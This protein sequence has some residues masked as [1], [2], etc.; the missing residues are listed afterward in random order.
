MSK[1]LHFAVLVTVAALLA[2]SNSETTPVPTNSAAPA[3]MPVPSPKSEPTATAMSTPT[4]ETMATPDPTPTKAPTATPEPAPTPGPEVMPEPAGATG[5]IAPLRMDDPEAFLAGL[6]DAERSCVSENSDPQALMALLGAPE[7]AS[8]DEAEQLIQCLEDETLMRLFLTGLIGQAGT[9]SE[10]TSE[11]IRGG[12]SGFD[13]RSMML[14]SATG[15]DE[16]AAMAGGMAAFFLTLSCLD[17]DEWAAAAP[18]LDMAPGD[19]ETLQCVLEAL[20][21]PEGVAAA[22]QPAGGGPPAAFFEAAMGCGMP[23]GASPGG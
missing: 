12:F 4:P 21:G 19:R 3:A 23:M 1:L 9:L 20:G 11:C 14:T 13:L 22:L 18:A 15:G 5:A 10:E 2:C 6:P 7:L 16:G 8:P 17:E